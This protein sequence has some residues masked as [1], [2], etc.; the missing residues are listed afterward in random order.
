MR[1]LHFLRRYPLVTATLAVGVAVAVLLLSGQDPLARWMGSLYS[2]AVAAK[3]SVGMVRD[4]LRG[5]WGI[6]I[7]AVT[8]IV[9]TVAVGEYV[10]SLIICLMLT[11]GG[12]LEDYAERRATRELSALLDRVPGTAHLFRPDGSLTEVPV[13]D[14][15]VGDEVLLRP[16]EVLAVDGT[17]VSEAADF[18]ESSLTGEPLPVTHTAGDS[19]MSGVLKIGRASCRERVL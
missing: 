5:H 14:V 19:V 2:L 16:S 1:I 8:A 3:V 11:G 7:L 6:D 17:L 12:A 10:A 15:A 9:S 4:V 13:G 18:D